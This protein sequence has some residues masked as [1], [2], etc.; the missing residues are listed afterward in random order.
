MNGINYVWYVFTSDEDHIHSPNVIFMKERLDVYKWIQEADYLVQLS[1]T[2]GLSYSINEALAYGKQVVVTPLPYLDEIGIKNDENA[3]ILNFDCSN[4][5]DVV[6]KIKTPKK[7]TWNVPNDNYGTILEKIKSNYEKE[8]IG[9]KR[10]RVK[11]KFRDMKHGNIL[12]STG[13]EFVEEAERADD[14]IN[15][16]Y[17]I[18]IEEIKQKTEKVEAAV[19]E[20]HEERAVP[21][22]NPFKKVVEKKTA[23]EKTTP[24][25][26]A[27]EK[28]ADKKT[29]KE[30]KN[31]KK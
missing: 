20:N 24:E 27:P 10:I 4:I 28:K 22:L 13:E 21:K 3:L 30:K 14:L 19:K 23:L 31:A 12:R 16:G 17:A 7:V 18:L 1:D 8:R 29:T 2:E 9:M 5:K 26:V 15:R 6:E 25:K 11:Q